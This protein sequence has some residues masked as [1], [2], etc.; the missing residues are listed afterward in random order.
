[1]PFFRSEITDTPAPPVNIPGTGELLATF[2]TSAGNITVRLFEKET[3]KTVANFV[4]LARGRVEWTRPDGR[5]ST[6]PLYDNTVFFRVIPE[7]MIQ[8][9]DPMGT[10]MGGPGWR[11]RNECRPTLRHDKPGRL[12]MA[13]AGPNTNGSQFFLTEVPTPWLDGKH[14]IFGEVMGGQDLIARIARAGNGKTILRTVTVFR[15]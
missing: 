4:A 1:M 6:A 13:N 9:G 12:S 11:F 7:F 10:G 15:A 5:P 8:G 2:E 14:T 3:P